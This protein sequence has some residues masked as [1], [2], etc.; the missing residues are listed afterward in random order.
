MTDNLLITAI[1][2]HPPLIIP[3]VGGSEII[4][5]AK[6]IRALETLSEKIV[7]L[8][9]DAIV[10]ITPHSVFNPYYF[11]IY[12]QDTLQ[13][14]F[15]RF[16][17]PQVALEFD[18]DLELIKNL[19]GTNPLPRDIMLDHGSLVP[20]YYLQKAGYKNKVA[21]INYTAMGKQE[22][23][24]FGKIITEAAQAADRKI[25]LIASGDLSH[26]L[27]PAAPAG[28]DES[29][30]LFDDLIVNSIKTGDYAA[31]EQI[32]TNMRE[33]AGECGYNS[34]MVA[35]GAIDGKPQNNEVLSYEGTFGVGYVVGI[36]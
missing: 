9:P 20:L 5:V 4:K 23:K 36:L 30:H 31:I 13:G 33:T 12:A 18:N 15:A 28:Y 6:T 17:A 1:V 2:P 32:T 14:N 25:A 35:L 10:I 27:K 8:N 16:R 22:H 3:E 24:A 19:K 21:V 11:S 29:A 34:L 7:N 26:K